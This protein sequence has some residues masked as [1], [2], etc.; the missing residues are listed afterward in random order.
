MIKKIRYRITK[1]DLPIIVGVLLVIIVQFIGIEYC[2][3]VG[4]TTDEFGY[5]YA[6]ASASGLDWHSVMQYHPYYSPL[7]AYLWI[8]L[9]KVFVDNPIG[10][11]RGIIVINIIMVVGILLSA[12]A[13][14]K[15]FLFKTNLIAAVAATTVTLYPAITY[16]SVIASPEIAL[17]LCYW[18][19][20]LL[21][22]NYISSGKRSNLILLFIVLG[23]MINIHNRTLAIALIIFVFL[24]LYS[25]IR[26]DNKG[27]I[28]ICLFILI[29]FFG[30]SNIF[31][32]IYFSNIEIPTSLNSLN[33][34]IPTT[35]LLTILFSNFSD[36][37]ISMV[38][39][40]YY[41][42][43]VGNV[44][45]VGSLVFI[46]SSCLRIKS[47][48]G[49]PNPIDVISVCIC[50]V[51]IGNLMAF[52]I[53]TA[54]PSSRFDY[55]F[56]S[57]YYENVLGPLFI[58]GFKELY[59]QRFLLPLTVAGI[60]FIAI[61]PTV[62][63]YME[64]VTGTVFAI[65]SAPGLGAVIPYYLDANSVYLPLL[66]NTCYVLMII[67]LYIIIFYVIQDKKWNDILGST[68]NIW[69]LLLPV[70]F[71]WTMI[72]IEARSSYNDIRETEYTKPEKIVKLIKS[73]DPEKVVFL[74]DPN[75]NFIALAKRLQILMPD[76][77]I[78]VE[79]YDKDFKTQDNVLYIAGTSE[80][81]YDSLSKK[82]GLAIRDYEGADI[83]LIKKS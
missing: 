73:M 59:N 16:H 61:T 34:S 39:K 35:S 11:Y 14:G 22:S 31:K 66:K 60:I 6:A 54:G 81:M 42:L 27:A 44:V 13:F 78:A 64:G 29:V 53:S 32:E 9:F 26:N 19:S 28:V 20:L 12:Y 65:D 15:R 71:Y 77:S 45:F 30:L 83:Y 7:V 55:L 1:N 56:Y 70:L 82:E 40:I 8:P 3:S 75:D 33:T 10:L 79:T 36:V 63:H 62:M 5:L 37:V 58:L 46:W 24:T 52:S 18:I 4:T 57:R 48:W 72:G 21:L 51:F 50:L 25:L 47:D 43:S 17:N 23:V 38:G 80:N 76:K 2:K 41:L 68:K 74:R 49:N 69:I 67:L